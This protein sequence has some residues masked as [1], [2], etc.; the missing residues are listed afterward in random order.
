MADPKAGLDTA[1][2]TFR[3][4][5]RE[6]PTLAAGLLELEIVDTTSGLC[7][8]E[9][10]FGNWGARGSE[11]DFLFFDRKRFDF[12][13]TLAIEVGDGALFSGRIMGLEGIFPADAPPAFAVLAEDALQDLRMVRRTRTFERMSDADVIARVARDHGLSPRV[14]VAG[15][16][17]DFIVQHNQSDLAFV[18]ER[19]RGVDAEVWL[20][21]S[22]LCVAP[23]ANRGGAPLRLG[24]GSE[25]VDFVALADLAEQRTSVVVGGWDPAAKAELLHEADASAIRAEL[26]GMASGPSTLLEVFGV[27]KETIVHRVPLGAAEAQARAEA[28]MRLRARRFV[29]G[30]GRARTSAKLRVGRQ[31][32]LTGL[33][34]L[35][36]GKYHLV[37]VRHL[38]DGK[39]GL[40]TEFVAERAGLGRG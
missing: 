40:R 26:D 24:Y 4:A 31:V 32:D 14:D 36:G 18:R 12:G 30:R 17:H 37:E 25:L 2:P 27:R 34:P 7:R 6:E 21:G 13:V 3:V 11:L 28:E 35:F 39:R 1:R 8:C 33:G 22:A 15:P 23:R 5:D 10:R 20:E 16:S 19:A 29:V 9:A 38:F